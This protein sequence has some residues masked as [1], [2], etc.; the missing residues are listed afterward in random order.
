[1]KLPYLAIMRSGEPS[2][3]QDH[4]NVGFG[5]PFPAYGSPARQLQSPLRNSG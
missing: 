4:E 3:I 5:A 1:M 2:L